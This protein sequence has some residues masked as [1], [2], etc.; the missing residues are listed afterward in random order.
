MTLAPSDDTKLNMSAPVQPLIE[1]G[2]DIVGVECSVEA[3]LPETT[4]EVRQPS[5]GR[6]EA[7]NLYPI[8]VVEE[9]SVRR[10]QCTREPIETECVTVSSVEAVPPTVPAPACT[11]SGSEVSGGGLEQCVEGGPPGAANQVET[12]PGNF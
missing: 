4:C 11:S 5:G 3:A 7:R 8:C 12:V 6:S 1:P 10:P 9:V 2:D